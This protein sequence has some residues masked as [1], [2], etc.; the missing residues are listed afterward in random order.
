M[1]M[2]WYAG[3]ACAGR[4]L[5]VGRNGG[6]VSAATYVVDSMARGADDAN[7]G[8]EEKPFKTVQHAADVA[9]PGDTVCV[10]A[11]K[12]DER[13]RVKVSG[14]AG[15]PIT[16][17]AMPRRSATVA[18]FD[19]QASYLRLEGFDITADQPAVAVQLDGSHCEVLDNYVHE[20]LMGVNGTYGRSIADGPRD[21]SAVAHNRVAYNKVYHSEYGFVLGGEDWLVENNEVERLF[22]YSPGRSYDDCDYTRFFGKGCVQ[23]CN[24]YHGTV[25]SEI[26]VAHVDCIQTFMGK[27]TMAQDVLIENNTCFDFGTGGDGRKQTEYRQRAQLDLAA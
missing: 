24:Y 4:K 14:A 26:K 15:Q 27:D 1:K 11:G 20:M 8:T 10:M 25:T 17:R 3:T 6:H 22:M 23:R 13:V 12:Y 9:K 19:L 5:P 16:F 7:A 2:R 18:G 21:Y